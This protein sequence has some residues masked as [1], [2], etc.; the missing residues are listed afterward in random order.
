MKIMK[1]KPWGE[2]Q[3]DFVVINEDDFDPKFHSK[4]DKPAPKKKVA[5]KKAVKKG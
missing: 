1:V 2:G 3:G 4:L 5:K